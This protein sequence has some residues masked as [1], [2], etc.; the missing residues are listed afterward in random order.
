MLKFKAKY[1]NDTIA[2]ADGTLIDKNSISRPTIQNKLTAN[3]AFA[4]MFEE[5]AP[6]EDTT[7]PAQPVTGGGGAGDPRPRKSTTKKA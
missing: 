7:P 3:K 1:S 6:A 4:Y 5:V 2:L